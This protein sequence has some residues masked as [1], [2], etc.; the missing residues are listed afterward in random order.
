MGLISSWVL[1]FVEEDEDLEVGGEKEE[2]G[3]GGGAGLVMRAP[4]AISFFRG[5]QGRV[6]LRPMPIFV[7]VAATMSVKVGVG[8]WGGIAV[9]VGWMSMAVWL[10]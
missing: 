3:G 8:G 2:E 1:E 6:P 7:E 9:V 10:W 4:W 5:A